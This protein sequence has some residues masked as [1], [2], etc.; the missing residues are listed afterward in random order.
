MENLHTSRI[1]SSAILEK[2]GIALHSN[3]KHAKCIVERNIEP[4]LDARSRL[5]CETRQ[6]ARSGPPR[7]E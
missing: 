3:P 1:A 2:A 7:C 5:P 4:F 6:N